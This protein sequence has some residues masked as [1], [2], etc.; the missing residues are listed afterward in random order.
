MLSVVEGLKTV[1]AVKTSAMMCLRKVLLPLTKH[2][3]GTPIRHRSDIRSDRR[4]RQVNL[5]DSQPVSV[6][7]V[8]HQL[9]K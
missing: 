1:E 4:M 3:A 2:S 5:G 9:M 7:L 8:V 6:E